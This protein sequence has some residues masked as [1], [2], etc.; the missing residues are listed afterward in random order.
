M[1]K[2]PPIDDMAAAIQRLTTENKELKRRL[3]RV[4]QITA[5][6]TDAF[7]DAVGAYEDRLRGEAPHPPF[8]GDF[9]DARPPT[10]TRIGWYARELRLAT[11]DAVVTIAGEPSMLIRLTPNE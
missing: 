11:S 7:N 1:P 9:W 10:L 5:K 8:N 2:T 6:L 3:S 4:I